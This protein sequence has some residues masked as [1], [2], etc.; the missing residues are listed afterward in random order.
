MGFLRPKYF[1]FWKFNFCPFQWGIAW[2]GT[3]NNSRD[4]IFWSC[5]VKNTLKNMKKTMSFKPGHLRPIRSDET[6]SWG[7][8]RLRQCDPRE[9]KMWNKAVN[10]CTIVSRQDWV[11]EFV[12]FGLFRLFHV[13][14]A[15]LLRVLS[16]TMNILIYSINNNYA[17]PVRS[18]AEFTH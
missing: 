3:V 10:L 8:S 16:A 12:T 15:E 5:M 13:E 4:I 1:F 11:C 18:N 7:I 17:R 2:Y 6:L 9:S 14:R